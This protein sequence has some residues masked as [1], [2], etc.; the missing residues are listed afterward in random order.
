MW[1]VKFSLQ[2]LYLVSQWSH[3][4]FSGVRAHQVRMKW[5]T[6]QPKWT[7]VPRINRSITQKLKKGLEMSNVWMG[8][9][10]IHITCKLRRLIIWYISVYVCILEEYI[11]VHNTSPRTYHI[12]GRVHLRSPNIQSV[13]IR[14]WAPELRNW[15]PQPPQLLPKYR[16]RMFC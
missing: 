9:W 10:F 14:T 6:S 7:R 15:L 11:N 13:P 4:H 12:S 16:I 8:L 1:P 2:N 3:Q 5:I